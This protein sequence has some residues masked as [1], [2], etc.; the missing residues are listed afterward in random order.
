MPQ[1][2]LDA[3]VAGCTR[4]L[5]GHRPRS[6]ADQLREIAECPL[7]LKPSDGYGRGGY[8]AEFEAG[9]ARLLGKEAAVFMPSGTM[10]QQIALRIWADEA[11]NP[12]I[13]YHPTCHLEIHEQMAYRELHHLEA[14]LVGGRDRMFTLADLKAVDRAIGP[15]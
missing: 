5:R 14:I 4:F 11:R 9:I 12:V 13:A 3:L 10:A 6:V 15:S 8:V 2:E 7:A 1:T